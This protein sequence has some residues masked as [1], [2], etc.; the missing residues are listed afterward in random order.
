LEYRVDDL[1]PVIKRLSF[2]FEAVQE[3]K[4]KKD[5]STAIIKNILYET[6]FQE[7]KINLNK[8]FFSVL[9]NEST[10]ISNSKLLCISVQYFSEQ[11]GKVVQ[12]LLQILKL[13]SKIGKFI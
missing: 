8:I 10:D 2:D 11:S 9:V 7:T 6:A 3:M 1:V 13:D 5:K 12:H 4:L